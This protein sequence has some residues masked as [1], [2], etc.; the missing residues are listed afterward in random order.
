MFLPVIINMPHE[1]FSEF[2]TFRS[3]S[4]I[5]M[6]VNVIMD[7]VRFRGDVIT[8]KFSVSEIQRFVSVVK[9]GKIHIMKYSFDFIGLILSLS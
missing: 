7:D 1:K 2:V 5:I 8:S 3:Y 6:V 4:I 9:N